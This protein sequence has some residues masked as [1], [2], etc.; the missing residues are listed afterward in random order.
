M[1]LVGGAL[2]TGA[3]RRADLLRRLLIHTG[4]LV[5][6]R[7]RRVLTLLLLLRRIWLLAT[8]LRQRLAVGAVQLRVGRWVMAAP[9]GVRRHEGLRLGRHRGED[10]FLGEANAVGAATVFSLIEARAADLNA[11]QHRRR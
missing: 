8:A 2:L 6:L 7:R 11:C 3:G 1:R 9:Y 4:L 5:A 10:A